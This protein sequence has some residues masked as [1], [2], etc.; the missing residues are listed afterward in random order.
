[1]S[2]Y[3]AVEK[4]YL[5]SPWSI[6]KSTIT[7]WKEQGTTTQQTLQ[8]KAIVFQARVESVLVPSLPQVAQ[9][10]ISDTVVLI[11]KIIA[12]Q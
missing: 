7:N 5:I 4:S 3:H 9:A 12:E 2:Q 1:M 10:Y 6:I 11:K 8:E